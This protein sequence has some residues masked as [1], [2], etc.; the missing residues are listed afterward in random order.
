MLIEVY[1]W[2][3]GTDG[4]PQPGA[5]GA[6]RPRPAACR[7][8]WMGRAA[9]LLHDPD[10]RP[11]RK[12]H[13]RDRRRDG[14]HLIAFTFTGTDLATGTWSVLPNGPAW[15]DAAGW[16]APAQYG[17]IHTGDLD[18][19]G[20]DDV[21]GLNPNEETIEAV[22]YDSA[23]DTWP[24]LLQAFG[25]QSIWGVSPAYWSTLQLADVDGDG[26]DEVVGRDPEE[27]GRGSSPGTRGRVPGVPRRGGGSVRP[28]RLEA[29]A[30]AVRLHPHRRRRR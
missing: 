24:A 8:G 11:R 2:A 10:R 5:V 18:G 1:E 7:L 13:R 3:E 23:T 27:M 19:N 25:V 15:S 22:T 26:A 9:V 30:R 20:T 16:D 17:T 29:R 4:Q 21:I 12:R 14:D 6:R 28:Q